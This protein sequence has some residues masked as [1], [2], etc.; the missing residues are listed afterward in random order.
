MHEVPN[1]DRM[2]SE[3]LP[4]LSV[5]KR[6]YNLFNAAFTSRKLLVDGLL[7]LRFHDVDAVVCEQHALQPLVLAVASLHVFCVVDHS[8]VS[9]ACL[10][11]LVFSDKFNIM[12]AFLSTNRS[13]G[14]KKSILAEVCFDAKRG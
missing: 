14:R 5:S 8:R 7:L 1:K 4:H 11:C 12:S 10:H 9:A 13:L 6:G 3:I 2:E